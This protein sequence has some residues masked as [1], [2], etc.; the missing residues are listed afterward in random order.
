MEQANSK[1]WN[2]GVVYNAGVDLVSRGLLPGGQTHECL[3][4][5]DVDFIPAAQGIRYGCVRR[6]AH[7]SSAPSQYGDRVPYHLLRHSGHHDRNNSGLTEIYYYVLSLP[8]R[9][10]LMTWSRYVSFVG[11]VL[12]MSV[13]DYRRLN[14][15][16]NRFWGWGKE[17]DDLCATACPHPSTLRFGGHLAGSLP[18]ALISSASSL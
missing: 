5:H 14:G 1:T 11:G 8:T 10:L 13:R 18:G 4:F 2:K 16:S 3:V 12:Q 9:M 7:L 6:P 17:D 15:Y